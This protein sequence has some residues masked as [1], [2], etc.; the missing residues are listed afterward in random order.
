MKEHEAR[1][2]HRFQDVLKQACQCKTLLHVYSSVTALYLSVATI[3]KGERE[4]LKKKN[5][6]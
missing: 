5:L 1:C 6:D 3:A 4:K 2:S